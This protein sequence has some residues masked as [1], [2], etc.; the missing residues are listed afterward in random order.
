M[1]SSRFNIGQI[2]KH[3]VHG[4]AAVIAD[5]DSIFQPSGVL[6][7]RLVTKDFSKQ[8]PWYR[9]LVNESQLI[10]YAD[11]A[12]L[13]LIEI[14]LLIENPKLN[15]YLDYCSGFYLRKGIIH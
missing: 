13:E 6:H 12:D 3:R 9:L 15:D 1:K 2:V 5:I 7:S 11:E 10:T 14:D 4:Y 8:G